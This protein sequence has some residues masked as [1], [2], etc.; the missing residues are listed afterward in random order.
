[1]LR[2]EGPKQTPF[3]LPPPKHNP[4]PAF[5]LHPP[6]RDPNHTSRFVHPE[7][8][9]KRNLQLKLTANGTET[10]LRFGGCQTRPKTDPNRAPRRRVICG[11]GVKPRCRHASKPFCASRVGRRTDASRKVRSRHSLTLSSAR[12]LTNK[13]DLRHPPCALNKPLSSELNKK[14]ERTSVGVLDANEAGQSASHSSHLSCR[15]GSSPMGQ[16]DKSE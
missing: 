3:V 7:T 13:G 11:Q 15:D 10:R 12:M 4:K 8:R 16:V 14:H 9:P 1:M 2:N 5:V 6:K